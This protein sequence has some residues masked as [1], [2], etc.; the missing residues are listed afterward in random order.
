MLQSTFQTWPTPPDVR[1]PEHVVLAVAGLLGTSALILILLGAAGIAGALRHRRVAAGAAGGAAAVGVLYLAALLLLSAVSR[2]RVLPVRARKYFCEIDCHVASSVE[3]VRWVPSLGPPPAVPSAGG[4]LAV[5]RLR[6]WFDPSTISPARGSAPLTPNPRETWIAD[7]RGRRW[8]LSARGM[9]A[10]RN[11][12]LPSDPL[13]RPLRPGE[14]SLTTLVF[15]VPARLTRPR[16][17]FG[18]PPG[19][20][21]AL[22]GHENSLGHARVFFELPNR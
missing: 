19:V 9:R 17:F 16:L 12:G 13:D 14:S 2:E 21:S 11:I 8:P 20:E 18:A 6:T 15:D 7:D 10:A 5:V 4:R 22:L 3:E 1:V